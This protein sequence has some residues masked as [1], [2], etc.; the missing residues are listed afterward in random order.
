MDVLTNFAYISANSASSYVR[1]IIHP[2]GT[3][4]IKFEGLRHPCVE[5]QPNVTFI[6]ND[7]TFKQS[8]SMFSLNPISCN[9]LCQVN[10]LNILDGKKFCIVT[11]PNMGGKSTFLRSVGVATLLA[12]VGCYVPAESAEISI[13]DGILARVGA[14]DNLTKGV[15]TF[16]AEM[17]E[18]SFILKVWLI[19]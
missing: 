9:L 13:V 8:M 17:I 3:G 14:G 1:P 2:K 11:G 15:S 19:D 5:A 18:T 7:I 10:I 4:V 6:P 16:M 12:Q